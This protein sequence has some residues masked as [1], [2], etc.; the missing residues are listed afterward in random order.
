MS[1]IKEFLQNK[2]SVYWIGGQP[3]AI[4]TYYCVKDNLEMIT[5]A[6][7]EQAYKYLKD[8]ENVV[9]M[10]VSTF[11]KLLQRLKLEDANK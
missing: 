4:E 10:N 2:K 8:D 9:V 11:K 7:K 1:E 3:Y 5:F 6:S